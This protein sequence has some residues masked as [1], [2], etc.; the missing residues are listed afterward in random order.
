MATERDP[1]PVSYRES[2]L[3]RDPYSQIPVLSVRPCTGR[4]PR[5]R[6]NTRGLGNGVAGAVLSGNVHTRCRLVGQ[7]VGYLASFLPSR[8]IA[9]V[10][11]STLA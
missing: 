3:S 8:P 1:L 10:S 11:A 4:K 7:P 9:T 6:W 2:V 5:R